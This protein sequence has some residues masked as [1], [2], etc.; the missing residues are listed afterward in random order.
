MKEIQEH[1]RR[2]RD[3]EAATPNRALM[4]ERERNQATLDAWEKELNARCHTIAHK[5]RAKPDDRPL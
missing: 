3:R 2:K 1:H 4:A 5:S